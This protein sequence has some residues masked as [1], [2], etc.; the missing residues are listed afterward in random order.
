MKKSYNFSKAFKPCAIISCIVIVLGIVGLIVRGIN[1][2]TDYA[3]GLVEEVRIAPAAMEITYTGIASVNVETSNDSLSLV[4]SGAGADN[5]TKVFTFG[6][7]PTISAMAEALNQVEGISAVVKSSGEADTYG[8]FT[9]SLNTSRLSSTPFRLYVPDTS[10]S[11]TIDDV[12]SA[13][14]G[15]DI[16]K[17]QEK[18]VN[19]DKS[20]QITIKASE[21]SSSSDSLQNAVNSALQT[22]FGQN[23]VAVVQTSYNAPAS[24]TGMVISSIL[25]ALA[26]IALIWLYAT[27]RFHW[28]FALGAII[29]LLHDFCIMFTFIT[30]FQIEFSATTLAAVL[31]IFGYSINATVVILDRVREALKTTNCKKFTEVLDIALNKT[32][33][34]S[35]I[36]TVTT[37]FASISLWVFTSGSIETFAIVLTI[38]LISGCYS[39]MFI[40]SGF[41][42]LMRR[43]WKPGEDAI[44]V[45]PHN[46]TPKRPNVIVMPSSR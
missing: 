17:L 16:D 11:V 41:I 19:A 27:I 38:G 46:N 36:T 32:I 12:R 10:S 1:F 20:F 5:E 15:V 43:A 28:D 21:E 25:L 31:T 2:T 22:K 39:S 3:P 4:I 8:I 44:H 24:S 6:Q 7:N 33:S 30:W 13:L 40:S 29:A 18:G 45:R 14:E 35:I 26:T 42:A 23:N 9:N 34:R 37:L